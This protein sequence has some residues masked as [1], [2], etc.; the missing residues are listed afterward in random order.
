MRVCCGFKLEIT[1]NLEFG[2]LHVFLFFSQSFQKHQGGGKPGFSWFKI[3]IH[4]AAKYF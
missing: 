4:Q 3:K 1:L 2:K